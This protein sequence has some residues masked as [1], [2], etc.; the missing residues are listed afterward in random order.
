MSDIE[1]VDLENSN[2]IKLKVDLKNR[3]PSDIPSDV[4]DSCINILKMW[5]VSFIDHE[6]LQRDDLLKLTMKT[7]LL[8]ENSTELP[9]Q[10]KKDLV[11]LVMRNLV[12]N[13]S[14]TTSQE[15]LRNDLLHFIDDYLP[16]IIDQSISISKGNIDIG[17][18]PHRQRK[19][20]LWL[21]G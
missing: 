10:K 18:K 2:E 9:G 5:S 15:E 11:I 7:I 20:L 17:K 4:F 19:C 1:T 3:E 16:F 12:E 6:Y 14:F 21:C 8:V 13:Y